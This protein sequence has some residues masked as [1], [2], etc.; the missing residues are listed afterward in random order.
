M[1]NRNGASVHTDRSR[2]PNSYVAVRDME[3]DI[4][5]REQK[6][7]AMSVMEEVRVLARNNNTGLTLN[8]KNKRLS[9]FEDL[10]QII[11]EDSSEV[12][13]QVFQLL[14]E[15]IPQF[16]NDIDT[17]MSPVMPY[18]IPCLADR[19]TSVK[20]GV[21]Q[22]LHVYMKHTSNLQRF[23]QDLIKYGIEN[24]TPKTRKE[25][26]IALPTLFTPE[27][28]HDDFCDLAQTLAKKIVDEDLQPHVLV[29]M[30]KLR[31]L[32]GEATFDA[33][34]QKLSAP[35]RRYCY[36][37]IDN[38]A[39]N[40]QNE[41]ASSTSGYSGQRSTSKSTPSQSGQN[42]SYGSLQFGVVPSHIMEKLND[43]GNFRTRAQAVEDLKLIIKGLDDRGVSMLNPHV[44]KFISFLNNLLDDTNFKITT[45]TLEIL[46]E[47]VQKLG[48]A[49]Q[50]HL[51]PMANCIVKRMDDNKVVIRQ[52]ISKCVMH[53]MQ[54]LTPKPVLNVICENLSHRNSRVRQETLNIIIASLL[55]FPS[56]DFDLGELS[57]TIAHTLVDP[58]RQVRQAAL[59]CFAVIA[60]AMG[61]NKL[62]PLVQAVD[63]V[64]LGYDGE[65][66][67]AA[68]Q[69]RL[70][71]RQLPR[72]NADRLI[73][74]ATPLPSQGSARGPS[75]YGL[76]IEWILQG[77]GSTGSSARSTRSD[78][79]E[80]ESVTSS[81]RSTPANFIHDHS[82][83]QTPKRHTSAGRK[84][85][86]WEDE[87]SPN[88]ENASYHN[89]QVR[90]F[91]TDA[92][93]VFHNTDTV[94]G[95][96]ILR[97]SI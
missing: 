45:V 75:S 61:P 15:V 26:I 35:L 63:S 74:Y 53:L 20:R 90:N 87:S 76:D 72:L 88:G 37:L 28:A 78:Y 40:S 94:R 21:L 22:T 17:F 69:A 38:A 67:M 25:V 19:K 55:T 34:M 5:Q 8:Q 44:L 41:R 64:E 97:P 73:E 80:L 31:D 68:V 42:N 54:N 10:G 59:E 89:K 16:D 82:I 65:G 83:V 66:V 2:G 14:H 4:A 96:C 91:I 60:Q 57:Q 52:A 48:M 6:A 29:S 23:Q 9:L 43:Q 56:Y 39:N 13:S 24:S 85:L 27:F 47:L 32:V 46:G 86:P 12:Q 79:M 36:K 30:E 3:D 71:R 49:I 58:K 70:T 81:A 84:R 50:P 51:R 95:P 7:Y 33:Y 92:M 18:L 1:A 77:S 11:L 93:P 62:Q